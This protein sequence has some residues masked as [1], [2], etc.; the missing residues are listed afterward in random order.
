[1]GVSSAGHF[2]DKP[3]PVLRT[4][5]QQALDLLGDGMGVLLVRGGVDAAKLRKPLT[6]AGLRAA[7]GVAA[8]VDGKALAPRSKHPAVVWIQRSL[9][10]IAAR[11][12]DAPA[13]LRLSHWGADADYGGE[14][15]TAIK[16]WQAHVGQTVDGTIGPALV[17]SLIDTLAETTAPDLLKGI[18]PIELVSPGARLLV[19]IAQG[20]CDS[21]PAQPYERRVDGE[22]YRYSARVFG[23]AAHERGKL[24]APGGVSY[25]LRPGTTY[26][27]CNI[28]AGTV[29]ALA[30]LPVPSFRWSNRS[31]SLHFP[32]AERFG[33]RLARLPGW[34]MVMQLDHRDPDDETRALTGFEQETDIS[35]LLLAAR[36]GDLLFVDHPGAPGNDGGHCRICIEPADPNDADLAPRFAQASSDQAQIT[37][38]G[39]AKMGDGQE[40]QFWLVRYVG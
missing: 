5:A 32:R 12:S 11:R 26:W 30:D 4:I 14:T 27:K 9:Q 33:G 8:I 19:Q 18:D 16:A 21:T 17:R 38:D 20:I 2:E 29:I 1:V 36:P 3:A 39:L 13:A 37:A 7:S 24:R 35:E 28:F 15:V 22:T 23:T 10:A 40:I 6:A 31:T 34:R 25:G